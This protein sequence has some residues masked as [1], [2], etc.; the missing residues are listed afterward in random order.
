M[1]VSIDSLKFAIRDSNHDFLYKT[2]K[3]LATRLVKRQLEKAVGEAVAL[4]VGVVEEG[5]GRVLASLS[6]MAGAAKAQSSAGVNGEVSPASAGGA[7]ASPMRAPSGPATAR[8]ASIAS[9]ASSESR[10]SG[11]F[12]VV[13][14]PRQS[15]LVGEGHKEGWEN[16]INEVKTVARGAGRLDETSWRSEA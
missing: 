16:K 6:N 3:P 4:A 11:Q 2:L 13:T 15:L 10:K 12:K 7:V 14:D 8:V 9:I 1:N 5:V